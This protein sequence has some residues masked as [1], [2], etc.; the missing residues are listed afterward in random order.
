MPRDDA[1]GIMW[2]DA[3]SAFAPDCVAALRDVTEELDQEI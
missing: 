3:G 2:K 1:L